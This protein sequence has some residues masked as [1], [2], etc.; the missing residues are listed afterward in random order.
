V[1]A[2][3][4]NYGWRWRGP[5]PLPLKKKKQVKPIRRE[6]TPAVRDMGVVRDND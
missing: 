3:N 2:Y 5:R 6:A 1:S 4:N